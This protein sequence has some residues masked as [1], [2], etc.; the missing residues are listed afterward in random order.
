MM[1]EEQRFQEELRIALA[2]SLNDF[3]RDARFAEDVQ[4][5]LAPKAGEASPHS[6]VTSHV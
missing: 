5:T 4:A 6:Q 3:Q 1:D 2:L